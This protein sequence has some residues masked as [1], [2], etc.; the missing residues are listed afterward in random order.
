MQKNCLK[1]FLHGKAF[2]RKSIIL[3]ERIID[4]EKA[5][6]NKTTGIGRVNSVEL[7]HGGSL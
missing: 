3:K 7:T 6:W 5:R 2:L 4:G 1:S